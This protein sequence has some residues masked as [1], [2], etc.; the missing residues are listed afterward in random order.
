MMSGEW[1][2]DFSGFTIH[3]D[4]DREAFWEVLAERD[5][6]VIRRLA[7]PVEEDKGSRHKF[8]DRGE[9]LDPAAYGYPEST[10]RHYDL[11]QTERQHLEVERTRTER[12]AEDVAFLKR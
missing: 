8:C 2:A 5:D 1:N 6:P 7:R 3:G 10:G 9:L 11:H 4:P 12:A